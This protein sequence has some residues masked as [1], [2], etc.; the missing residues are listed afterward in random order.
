MKLDNIANSSND[1]FYT[2]RYAIEPII[3][4]LNVSK[5][6]KIWCPFDTDE[7]LFVHVLGE[8]SFEVTN[9]HILTGQDFFT[10][11]IVDC[12]CIISNPPYSMKGKVFE[13]LFNLNKPFAMLV[14]VVGLFESQHRFNLFKNNKFEIMYFNKR[15]AYFK[16]YTEQTP[17]LNPPFSSVYITRDLL[18]TSI[19]FE[20]LKK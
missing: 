18:P 19:C 17:S 11:N 10:T 2:P 9:T 6:K 16:N 8:N 13:R 12:D 20:T 5:Y 4:Y 3:K 14:G 7:S 1:E 15:I